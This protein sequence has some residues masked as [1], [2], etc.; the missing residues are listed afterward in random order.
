MCVLSCDFFEVVCKSI[1]DIQT[2]PHKYWREGVR[3]K[4]V[5]RWRDGGRK[6]KMVLVV[7]VD[8]REGEE[9]RQC[10]AEKEK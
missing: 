3:A 1:T 5:C 8:G 2:N 7:A 9:R 6:V 10:D 4:V